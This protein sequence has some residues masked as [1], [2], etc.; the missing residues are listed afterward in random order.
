MISRRLATLL[1][2]GDGWGL[3]RRAVALAAEG[4]PVT[5]LNI[6]EHDRTT[7]P[8]ILDAMDRAARSGH[9]GYAPI[10]GIPELRQEVADRVTRRTGVPTGPGNVV[11]TPGG[12]AGLFAAHLAA[13]DPGDAAL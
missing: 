9:T 4:R 7:P 1:P 12:Q 13:L 2:D 10:S 3:Y 8:A 6:G 11:I 5:M